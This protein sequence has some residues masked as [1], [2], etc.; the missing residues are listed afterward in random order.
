MKCT[1]QNLSLWQWDKSQ[2]GVILQGIEEAYCNMCIKAL[3]GANHS[4][5]ETSL[6]DAISKAHEYG[7]GDTLT[8][9]AIPEIEI[10]RYVTKFDARGI[11]ITE[12]LGMELAGRVE[13]NS[14]E[15]LTIFFCDPTDRSAPLKKFLEL[16]QKPGKNVG[17]IMLASDAIQE[18]EKLFGTP[19]TITGPT[20]AIT[21]VRE[22][23]PVFAVILNY[24]TQ[25]L[26]LCCPAGIK[27]TTLPHYESELYENLDTETIFKDGKDIEFP[28]IKGRHT[29]YDD[30]RN[31][32]TFL[33]KEGYNEHLSECHI[34]PAGESREPVYREPGGPTRP[35]YL[36]KLFTATPIGFILA[37]GEKIGEWIHWLTFLRFAKHEGEQVFQIFELTHE[38]PRTREGISMAPSNAYS[39]FQGDREYP[40]KPVRIDVRPLCL[41][42]KPSLFRAT[43]VFTPI[44]NNWLLDVMRS[45][46]RRQLRFD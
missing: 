17:N 37:N 41:L 30:Y 20:C 25:E 39:V 29:R 6:V 36:S 33:G 4:L 2:K 13:T 42:H 1:L 22:G 12:E 3:L 40:G 7:K 5:M 16:R 15:P 43:L 10:G 27:I 46:K 19:V 26:I 18:W 21:C 11:L 9:D 28:L 23:L 24:I 44:N 8:I 31:F 45:Y 38:R 32:I 35:L 34:F 14:H